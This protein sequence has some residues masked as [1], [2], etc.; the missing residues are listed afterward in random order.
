M[1]SPLKDLIRGL[2]TSLRLT[3]I[4][5]AKRVGIS[6][7][8]LQGYER[9]SVPSAGALDKMKSLAVAEGRADLAMAL[10]SKDYAVVNIFE[11]GSWLHRNKV[12]IPKPKNHLEGALHEALDEIL[13][14]G[15]GDLIAGVEGVLQGYRQLANARKM[16]DDPQK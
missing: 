6:L 2:R 3:Q 12:R 4:D 16:L 1:P 5:F 9:G 10:G 14:S 15:Q 11:P 7:S 8:A 13:E